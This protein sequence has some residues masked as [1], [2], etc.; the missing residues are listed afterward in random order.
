MASHFDS[1]LLVRLMTERSTTQIDLQRISGVSRQ[2]IGSLLTGRNTTVQDRTV[3]RLADALGVAPEVFDKHGTETR[4]RATV[5]AEHE[6]LDFTALG[7]IDRGEAM[8]MDRGF[9]PIP[10]ME[11]ALQDRCSDTLA[12]GA[13]E[14]A[15]TERTTGAS[16][17]QAV[18]PP[19]TSIGTVI[20]RSQRFFIL[21]D[22]GSGKTTLLRFLAR[23]C[24][25]GKQKQHDL[26]PQDLVPVY[27]RLACWS[28]QLRVDPKTCVIAAAL[29]QLPDLPDGTAEWLSG[30]CERGAAL[31]LMDG[32]DEVPDPDARIALLDAIRDLVRDYPKAR[33]IISSRFVGFDSPL[34]GEQF[35]NCHVQPLAREAVEKFCTE[36][37]AHRHGHPTSRKCRECNDRVHRVGLS[38]ASDSAVQ[39]L[40]ANP[41]MLTILLLLDDAGAALPRRRGDLYQ[42]ICETFLFSWQEKKRLALSGAPDSSL[43]LDD[44]EIQWVLESVAL[45]MQEHDWT[46]VQRWWLNRHVAGFLRDELGF[47]LDRIN[48]EADAII[49]SLHARCGL[50][51][52]RGTDRFGFSHLAFQEYCA[53]RAILSAEN[54]IDALRPWFYHPRWREV[55]HL[56]SAQLDRRRVP[57]LFRAIM[58]DPDPTGR[59]LHRG[60]LI[61]LQCLVEGA[62]V[63]DEQFLQELYKRIEHAGETKWCGIVLDLLAL[64]NRLKQTRLAKFAEH[65]EGLLTR[66][67]W[68]LLSEPLSAG[69]TERKDLTAARI[70]LDAREMRRLGVPREARIKRALADCMDNIELM[71]IFG[72]AARDE[73]T[74]DSDIDLMVIGDAT[75]KDL[76]PGLRRAEQELNKQ[77]NVVVYSVGEWQKRCREGNT[78]AQRVLSEKKI[79]LKGAQDELAAMAGK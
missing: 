7:V 43:K 38:I 59:I 25:M 44:R 68:Q 53:A 27:V 3:Q 39:D 21:G 49:W 9:I 74:A 40:A 72:S 36:W 46:L 79:F 71:F 57:Q 31:L 17:L 30:Q 60:L 12:A 32:L 5:A 1:K 70:D 26:P 13:S 34:S 67:A 61:V 41:M 69:T 23:T 55:V 16:S 42:K 63:L 4:Y 11:A 73:Q 15:T 64:M 33:I 22:P 77:V 14:C 19:P 10:L 24:A 48:A 52:E 50:L 20:Q 78:F 51:V 54:P 6:F 35:E 47:P 75:L 18:L 29:T 2:T 65:A 28:E 37:S 45:R 8:P 56:V 66:P 58:D 62:T 76:A